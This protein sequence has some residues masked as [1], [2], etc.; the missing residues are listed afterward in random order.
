ML[1]RLFCLLAR[2]SGL[3]IISIRYLRNLLNPFRALCP[4]NIIEVFVRIGFVVKQALFFYPKKSLY[5]F[6]TLGRCNVCAVPHAFSVTMNNTKPTVNNLF[7]LLLFWHCHRHRPQC[8]GLAV[9]SDGVH[10]QDCRCLGLGD[11]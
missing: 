11:G 7:I 10:R 3:I 4:L 5:H 1:D 2:Y 9:V 8:S 6:F